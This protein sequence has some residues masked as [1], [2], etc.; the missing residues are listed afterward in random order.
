M[1]SFDQS[2]KNQVGNK[3][4]KTEMTDSKFAMAHRNSLASPYIRVGVF[5]Y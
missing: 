5:P 1:S 4:V 3:I 2:K